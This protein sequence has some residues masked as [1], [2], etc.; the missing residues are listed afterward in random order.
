MLPE[1][2]DKIVSTVQGVNIDRVAV[3]DTGAGGNGADA[4][5]NGG[6]GI[7][8]MMSQLPA[9]L[10]AMTEQIETATG[11]DLLAALR[12]DAGTDD[13]SGADDSDIVI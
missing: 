3:I 10:V 2:I 6:G 5:S 8:G 1:L 12:R 4:K 9:A 11:V 7:P 13:M